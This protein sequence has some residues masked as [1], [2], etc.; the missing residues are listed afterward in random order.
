MHKF[1]RAPIYIES[2]IY[3]YPIVRKSTGTYEI[4]QREK[5]GIWNTVF[6]FDY[7]TYWW[8]ILWK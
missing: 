1:T 7:L 5:I 8:Y 6:Y 2:V 3:S 4:L